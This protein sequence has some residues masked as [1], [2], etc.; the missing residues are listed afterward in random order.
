M[1]TET[2]VQTLVRAAYLAPLINPS[3]GELG[4][5]RAAFAALADAQWG[6]CNLPS[7]AGAMRAYAPLY[8]R[9]LD[10]Q[11]KL[12]AG[13]RG[14]LHASRYGGAEAEARQ[15]RGA[16]LLP[17]LLADIEACASLMDA[18]Q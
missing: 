9:L 7:A 13:K 11:E 1:K 16:G 10:A 12:R 14:G 8:D 15:T 17:A 3:E 5:V 18:V 4:H 2:T 6:I